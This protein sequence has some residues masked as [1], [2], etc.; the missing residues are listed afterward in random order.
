VIVTFGIRGRA[1]GLKRVPPSAE[2]TGRGVGVLRHGQ[3]L[4]ELTCLLIGQLT[5]NYRSRGALV[6]PDV[7]PR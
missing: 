4:D 6:H 2:R 7:A 3:G 1:L 5:E